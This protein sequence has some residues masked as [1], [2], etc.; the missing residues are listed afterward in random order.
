M[1]TD[2][3][4]SLR[5]KTKKTAH[6]SAQEIREIDRLAIEEVGIPSSVLMEN[7]GVA[8][9]REILKNLK[10]PRATKVC[11]VC[12]TGNNG[13]DGFVVARHLAEANVR[14]R[15]FVIG[16]RGSFKPDAQV[17]YGILK[18]LGQKIEFIHGPVPGFLKALAD[19]D[20]VVDALFGVGLNRDLSESF[21]RVIE[22][23]NQHSRYTVAVDIP[24][25][26]DAT[27]GKVWGVGI[28]AALTVT[29]SCLKQGFFFNDGRRLTGR[30]VVADIGIPKK[31]YGRYQ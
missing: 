23:I 30:V 8:T 10:K 24:S 28:K 27:T 26:L 18:N 12:G 31:I 6:V 4:N 11:V 7:A 20:I 25:G 9:A 14:L 1:K 2:S 21:Q 17:N 15:V 29:M 19:S 13:G 5:W 3:L 16:K 22:A